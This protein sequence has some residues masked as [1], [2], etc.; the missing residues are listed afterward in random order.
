M[1]NL[2]LS[3]PNLASQ[4]EHLAHVQ[5]VAPEEL[6]SQA[7]SEFLASRMVGQKFL[8]PQ[9]TFAPPEFLKEAAAFERLKPELMNKY[10]GR[11]VA[12][13]QEKVVKIGDDILD[14]HEQ[15]MQQYGFVPC[16]VE[17]V[18]AETPRKVRMPSVRKAR[19]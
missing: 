17:H 6:L 8:R 11:V 13:Y 3:E 1:G 19:S 10:P 15:V 4:L 16:Y 18:V 2:V 9:H 5:N 7:V 12:I 14:V